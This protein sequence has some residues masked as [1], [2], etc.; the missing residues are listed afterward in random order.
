MNI[1]LYMTLKIIAWNINGIRS[2][3]DKEYLYDLI[4]KE[5]PN[6]IC[7]GETKLTCPIDNVQKSKII[8]EIPHFYTFQV[9]FPAKSLF[10]LNSSKYY[11]I[12]SIVIIAFEN[13]S[14]IKFGRSI[15]I[16]KHIQSFQEQ[17]QFLADTNY[18]VVVEFF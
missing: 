12:C 11:F 17:S 18:V 7:F 10:I 5:K 14:L 6:I 16:C 9:I 2:I 1:L 13:V 3:I 4:D 15:C 8:T